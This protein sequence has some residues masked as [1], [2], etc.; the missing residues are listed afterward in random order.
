MEEETIS[1]LFYYCNDMQ[2]IWNQLQTYFTN[3]V[4]FSQL[5]PQTAIFGF[6][7]IESETF[8]FFQNHIILL[9]KL[10]IYNTRKYGFLSLNN[11]LN[12]IS[13]F[14]NLERRVA[15]NNR[16]KYERFRKIWHRMQNKVP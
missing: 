10:C 9:L 1:H 4:H 15:V 7:D 5:T 3:C 16:N 2:D 13:K 12:E 8:F 11:F 6:H 14:K